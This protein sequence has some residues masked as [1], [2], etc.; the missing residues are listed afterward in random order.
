[1]KRQA[2]K[3]DLAQEVLWDLKDKYV[4][5]FIISQ[6]LLTF[7]RHATLLLYEF[8]AC[9]HLKDWDYLG[10]IVAE[11]QHCEGS[12]AVQYFGDMI[13]QSQAPDRSIASLSHS[14][15]SVKLIVSV[16]R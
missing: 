16:Q 7:I 1:M 6:N 14:I 11:A 10:V 2:L 5:I 9:I 12:K 8:E 13:M 3:D 15:H 4:V